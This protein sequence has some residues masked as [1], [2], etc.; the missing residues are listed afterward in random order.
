M[1]P[2]LDG[3]FVDN[4]ESDLEDILFDDDEQ[5]MLMIAAKEP[6]DK[7]KN[8]LGSKV[9]RLCIPRNRALGHSMLMQDYFFEVPTYLAY[10]FRRRYRMRRSLFVKIV[11]TCVEK[12]QYFKRQRNAVGLLCFNGYQ[13][14]PAAMR[15]LPY[16]IP[17]DYADDQDTMRLLGENAARGWPGMLGSTDCMH[18]GWKN[19]PKAWH[20]QYCVKSHD[21]TIVLE[22]VASQDLWIWHC[23]FWVATISVCCKGPIYFLGLLVMMLRLATTPSLAM[24]TTWDITLQMA[25]LRSG[26]HM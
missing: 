14:I 2:L 8:R 26:Q 19:C 12:T 21:P 20:E 10:L 16:G 22:A 25:F 17:A 4:D 9:G 3:G 5:L 13:N 1:R 18:W 23:F 15:V 11:E 24:S 7:K 6:Q